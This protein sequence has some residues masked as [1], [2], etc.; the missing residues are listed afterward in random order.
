MT[1]LY[2]L[3]NEYKELENMDLDEDTLA[4]TLESIEGEFDAK[5]ESICHVLA[6]MDGDA[7]ELEREVVRL[8]SRAKAIRDRKEKL[9]EY[10]R[11]G[12][13]A[14]EKKKIVGL[15]FTINC[16]AGRDM[17]N[18]LDESKIP[19]GFFIKVPESKKLDKKD[20]LAKLKE[21]EVDG[22]ELIKSKSSL[23]IK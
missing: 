16:V 6:N 17:V 21:G 4:D 8:S 19:R 22:A 13:E 3:T 11:D 1:S 7:T 12:M 10:L 5:A 18:V 14:L 23:R 15:K 20:L 2:Q 9:G